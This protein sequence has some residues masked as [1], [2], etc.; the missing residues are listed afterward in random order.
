MLGG[1]SAVQTWIAVSVGR[2]RHQADHRADLRGKGFVGLPAAVLYSDAYAS[3]S[4][5]GRAVLVEIL[6]RFNGYNNG[7]IALSQREL[8]ERLGTSNFRRI[9]MATAELFV[10]GFIDVAVEGKWKQRHARQFRLTFITTGDGPPYRAA[11][12]DYLAF[13]RADTA[14]A[15]ERPSAD[16]G[17][18]TPLASA[19]DGSAAP[20]GK[21]SIRL[22]ASAD[23]GS[24]L[25]SKPYRAPK[26]GRSNPLKI[27]K[28][29]A[30]GR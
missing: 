7:K 14:S 11:T 6:G 19:D 24:T 2:R 26:S 27:T 10:A 9:S 23:T 16:T 13:S 4:L 29:Q 21:P 17:S 18:A 22:V 15:D 20:H 5:W 1:L 30:N 12:N 28:D 3:L 8:A 25:I